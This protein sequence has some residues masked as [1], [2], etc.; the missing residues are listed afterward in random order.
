MKNLKQFSYYLISLFLLTAFTGDSKL[1]REEAKKAVDEF[2]KRSNASVVVSKFNILE[3]TSI[4]S[5]NQ[6]S[7]TK[8]E[9]WITTRVKVENSGKDSFPIACTHIEA[10]YKMAF[11]FEKKADTWTMSHMFKG[12]SNRRVSIEYIRQFHGQGLDENIAVK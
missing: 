6:S 2:V 11:L 12:V 1:T 4:D 3:V 10:K 7:D 5:L 8:A 9:V